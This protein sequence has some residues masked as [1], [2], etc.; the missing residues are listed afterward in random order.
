M[1]L[2][3]N[4]TIPAVFSQRIRLAKESGARIMSLI[5]NNVKPL[6]ILTKEALTNAF[7]V[8]MA[9]GGSTNTILHLKALAEIAGIEFDLNELNTL[10]SVTPNLCR[11]SPAGKFYV[12][13]L[14]KAGGIPAVMNELNKKGLIDRDV[15]TVCEKKMGIVF[16]G[17]EIKNSSVIRPITA[18]FSTEGGLKVLFGNLSP[19]GSVVKK[20][21]V[22][23]SM[24]KMTGKAKVF[25]SEEDAVLSMKEGKITKGD[26]VV[27]RYEGSKG[28]PGMREMLTPTA[29]LAGLGLDKDVAL[30]T[31]GRF[32]GGSRGAVIGHVSPEAACGGLIAYVKDGDLISFDMMEGSLDLNISQDEI[33][34]RKKK[35]NIIQKETSGLLYRYGRSGE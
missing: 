1:A 8:D 15:I 4:G 25:N 13:D 26:I 19:E 33:E 21:A 32:S 18:P 35:E 20:S 14:H 29:T 22:D 7:T 11:L 9:L 28:G 27:I 12:E 31:D 3:G 34:L 30:I 16:K 10:S 6:D 2:P 24:I 23:K 17:H 5:R